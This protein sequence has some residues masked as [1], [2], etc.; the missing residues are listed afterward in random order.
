[1]KPHMPTAVTILI[2]VIILFAIY[3]FTLGKKGA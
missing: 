2:V 3:H 1:M